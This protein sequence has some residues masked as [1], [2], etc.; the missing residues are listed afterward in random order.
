MDGSS[1]GNPGRIGFRG[2]I[3]DCAGKWVIG[4]SNFGGH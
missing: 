4:F 3:R 1:I 2:L